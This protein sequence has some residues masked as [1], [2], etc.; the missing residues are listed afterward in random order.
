MPDALAMVGLGG[1]PSNHRAQATS[2]CPAH[3]Q[4]PRLLFWSNLCPPRSAVEG[5][6]PPRSFVSEAA[7]PLGTPQVIPTFTTWALKDKV[8]IPLA[9]V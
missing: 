4:I 6:F 5:G 7:L 2:P 3:K 9:H 1:P 8:L